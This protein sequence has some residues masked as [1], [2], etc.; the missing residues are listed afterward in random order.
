MKVVRS[1]MFQ[2][3]ATLSP[4]T[5]L[6]EA[7]QIMANQRPGLAVILDNMQVAGVLTE[8]DIIRWIVEDRDFNNTSLGDLRLSTPHMVHEDTPCQ[9]LLRIYNQ[10]RFRR[11]PVLNEDEM[12]S[13]GI[14]EKQILSAM[15]RSNLLNH[16]RISDMISQ[17]PPTIEPNMPFS[18]VA[19]LMVKWHRGCLLVA[20]GD[21]LLG[22][23]TEGELV[24]Q[25]LAE[26]WS[27]DMPAHSF[28]SPDPDTIEPQLNLGDALNVFKQTG[29]RRLPIVTAEGKLIGLLTQTDILKRMAH[30]ARTHEAVLNP[31]DIDEP[32][33][34]IQMEA[35]HHIQA[36]NQKGA[37]MLELD[38]DVW[39]D[40]SIIPL[41]PDPDLWSALAVVLANTRTVGPIN[42]TM[43]TGKGSNICVSSRLSLIHTPTG[44]DRIFW[45]ISNRDSDLQVCSMDTNP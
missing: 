15:P 40:K 33:V 19:E 27:P 44:E 34:W 5:T 23:I 7:T 1:C 6:H 12:L 28:S 17:P 30:S 29:H 8:Y 16:Y 10:R 42:L 9:E 11:F 26:N 36:M 43:K 2:N 32:A 22:I 13:G 14:M 35:P 18:Q 31:E 39:V 4:A 20:E 37:D 25:R 24:F 38:P 41:F 21:K 45:R 3:I